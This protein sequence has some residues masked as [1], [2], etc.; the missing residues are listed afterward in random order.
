MKSFRLASLL[1]LPYL[2]IWLT[3]LILFSPTMLLGKALFWG[4]PFLQFVPWRTW[5]WNTLLSGHL[6]LWNPMVGMGA[7]LAANYQS[8][9]F[10]PPN[11]LLIP[12]AALWG[13]PG[14]A[15]AQT[16]LV[17]LHL[18][19][20]GMGMAVLIRSFGFKPLAQAV[21]GLA[22]M[23]SGYLVG[24][25]SFFSINSAAAWTPW[26][27]L[28]ANGIAGLNIQSE[29][30]KRKP[31][32]RRSIFLI[33]C[34]ALQLLAGH[35]Q[36]TWYTLLLA[37]VWVGFWSLRQGGWRKLI[38]NWA[39]LGGVIMLASGLAAIQLLPTAEYLLQSQRASAVG[40][41]YALNYSFWPWRLITL[42]APD[43]Y[44]NPAQGNYW[45]NAYFYEDAVYIGLLP[46]LLGIGVL[47]KRKLP[48]AEGDAQFANSRIKPLLWFL[49][50]I[51]VVSFLLAM[52]RY[53]PVFPFLYR[54]IPTFNMFQGPTRWTLWAEVALSILAGAGVH[55]WRKPVKR[56]LYWTRLAT[57]GAFAVTL[58]AGLGWVILGDIKATFV[59]AATL[60]GFWG[61][62]VG[63]LS[64]LAPSDSQLTKK[65]VLWSWGVVLLVSADLLVA[66][67]GLNPSF[68]LDLYR[69][70]ASTAPQAVAAA[71][72][73]RLFMD[74][75]TEEEIKFERFFQVGTYQ[76][77]ESWQNLR[78]VLLPDASILDGLA[79][80]N[81]FDPLLP[82]R[83]TR[84]MD[85][86]N[87]ADPVSRE[88]LLRLMGVGAVEKVDLRGTA[89]VS[90]EK[91]DGAS[92][93]SWAN[94]VQYVRNEEQAL[95][96][97]IQNAGAP[98][99][100]RNREAVVVLE[101]SAQAAQSPCTGRGVAQIRILS[102]NPD[103]I[104][105]SI[106]ADSSGWL[107][108]ADEW[109]PGWIA[110][111]DGKPTPLLHANDLFR[112][113]EVPSGYHEVILRYRPASFYLG[114]LITLLTISGLGVLVGY[115]LK[116]RRDQE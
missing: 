86:I 20:A 98:V 104:R 34:L 91:V 2:P 36:V 1:R 69:Q 50:V 67:W 54:Y 48:Q 19:I 6:P 55:F 89:G 46:V 75:A 83:Y 93:Y 29:G 96:Q 60:A 73:Q 42:L 39:E 10:Y 97:V 92:R 52:G 80:A 76:L 94:C 7:P 24:R 18:V 95:N 116:V 33:I 84:W 82:E 87:Q 109:Y 81:N 22:F 64:L 51:T 43:F 112:A 77:G 62:G 110:E 59:R 32:L 4:T 88:N 31:F 79:S 106:Q 23:L 13:A 65:N 105:I 103:Q 102:E 107:V 113:I 12:F 68:S 25:A 66:D 5:A 63:G 56:A 61:L 3:P 70:P 8:A 45:F 30:E 74:A 11:W 57:A 72:G 78:N 85:A 90:F 37:G 21:G 38:Q 114:V 40:Y 71:D 41:D 27:L 99:D 26:V 44:G 35:A 14:V 15:W 108:Q 49:A 16:F 28:G 111:I 101:T 100:P 9:L 115:Q 53:T 47:F 17:V 58:G